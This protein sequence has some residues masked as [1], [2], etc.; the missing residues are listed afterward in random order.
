MWP[1]PKECSH[2]AGFSTLASL[3]PLSMSAST[4]CLPRVGFRVVGEDDPLVPV[5]LRRRKGR[6]F[7][8]ELA[9]IS[10]P[11]RAGGRSLSAVLDSRGHVCHWATSVVPSV[12]RPSWTADARHACR[13]QSGAAT[14]GMVAARAPLLAAVPPA[15]A[16]ALAMSA[17]ASC[18][19]NNQE[20]Q[21]RCWQAW[22][23]ASNHARAACAS[24]SRR[25]GSSLAERTTARGVQAVHLGAR[26]CSAS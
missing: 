1:R 14:H 6:D 9:R 22:R 5:V 21:W 11:D 15:A 12:R 10:S 19:R 17:A 2:F 26:W 4:H 13:P 16:V 3:R 7:R 24:G 23:N 25:P 18:S 20:Y 8:P